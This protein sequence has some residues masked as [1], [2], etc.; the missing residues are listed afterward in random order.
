MRASIMPKRSLFVRLSCLP[1]HAQLRWDLPALA[2]LATGDAGRRD[3]AEELQEA[4]E[5]RRRRQGW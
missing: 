1:Q 4:Q 2:V 5:E 3:A